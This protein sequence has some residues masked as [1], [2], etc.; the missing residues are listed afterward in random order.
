MSLLERFRHGGRPVSGGTTNKTDTLEQDALRLI[1]EGN[2]FEQ[3]GRME[4]AMQRYEAALRLAPNLARAHLN[5]GNILLEGDNTQAAIDAYATALVHDPNYAVAH[6][7]TGNAYVQAGRHEAALA[8]YRAAIALKPDFADAEV[9]M[10]C[11]LEDLGQLDAAV[12]SYRRALKINPSYVEVYG[13]LGQALQKLGQLDNAVTTYR[14]ALR[15]RPDFVVAHY[16]LGQVLHD[17]GQLEQAAASFE[18][19]VEIEPDFAVAHY[20][21]GSVL[22]NLGQ[23]DDAVASYGR[24]LEINPELPEA[25]SNLGNALKDLMRFDEAMASHRRALEI[26]PQFAEAHCNLGNVLLELGQPVE[27]VVSY[28]RALEINPEFSVAHNNLANVLKNLMRLDE[29]V[30]S[31]RRALEIKPHFAEAHCNLGSVLLELGQPVEAVASYRQALEVKPDFAE[32]HSN[33][34]NALKALGLLDE[35]AVSYRCA[36]KINPEFTEAH[37]NLGITLKD[38]GQFDDAIASFRQALRDNPDYAEAHNNL[39]NTLKDL[40]KFDDAVASYRRAL[41]IKPDF[42]MAYSNL[43]FV[44]NYT[45][46]HTVPYCLEQARRYGEML[47]TKKSATRFVAWS[48]PREPKRLRVGLVSGDLRNHPVGYFLEGLLEHTDPTRV[49]LIAYPTF[50]RADEVTTAIRPHFTAWKPVSRLSDEAAARLIHADGVH[51]LLDLSGHTAEN[52]LPIFAWK[53]APVQSSWLGYFATTGVAAID[54]VVG[55]PYVMRAEEAHHFTERIWR[56]PEC[57]LCFTPPKFALEAVP[58]PALSA[59]HIT[60]GSFNNLA[61]VNDAVVAL[62]AAVLQAVSGSRLVLKTAQLND[63]KMCETTRQRFAARGIASDRLTLEGSSP[64]AELLATY[65][66]VDI[67]LDPFPYPGG[68]TSLEGLWMGVPVITRGGDR[69]LSHVGE[70]IAHNAGLSDWIAAGDDEYVL[71]AVEFAAD[72]GYLATL[73]AGLRQRMLLSPLFNAPR[74]A[75]HLEAALWGMWQSWQTRQPTSL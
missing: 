25:H 2:A 41:E 19:V 8:A 16:N 35:A 68:T 37:Y 43:L 56:L 24:A 71:R 69:F 17:L 46:S 36:L 47:D 12:A 9:A 40:G 1:D 75:R 18:K 21:L 67:A 66:R 55:D 39:G 15:V 31:Y 10:G 57:Y 6:Y 72:L 49:E 60:F 74:F 54:Y 7:N 3:E 27:A 32:A 5:R 34:G 59:G 22:Q 14:T 50:D 28:R 52:R 70:S 63:F 53:P 42:A 38:L 30:A 45:A 13:N 11:V 20:N 61:K 23:L 58:L 48:C 64:R 73:R 29:A 51:I 26:R 33:L 62:W 4:E 65:N 44:L